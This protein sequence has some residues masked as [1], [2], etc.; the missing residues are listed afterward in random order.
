MLLTISMT[1]GRLRVSVPV[2]SS[3]TAR[4]LPSASSAAPP[5]INTPERVAAPIA[6]TTVTG[7]EMANAHGAAATSTTSERS[8]HVA[9]SPSRL[10]TTAISKAATMTPGTSGRATRSA[11][12]WLWPLRSWASS[13]IPT[14]RASELSSVCDV[15]STSSAAPPL[16]AAA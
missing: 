16:M 10:P 2:L 1:V 8:I 5:L 15:T 14:I 13:T 12:R 11:S 3:A 7:T 9:G 4:T 6:A